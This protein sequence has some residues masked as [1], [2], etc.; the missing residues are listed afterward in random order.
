MTGGHKKLSKQL[1]MVPE[2][3][4]KYYDTQ[5]RSIEPFKKGE[6]VRLN[7]KNIRSK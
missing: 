2:S 5:R 7:E 4:A 3:M 1:E 6:L